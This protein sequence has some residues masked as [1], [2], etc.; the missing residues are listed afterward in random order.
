MRIVFL[1]PTAQLG[2][3]EAALC[4]LLRGLGAVRPDWSLHVIAAEDGPLLNQMTALGITHE[5]LALPPALRSL[6]EHEQGTSGLWRLGRGSILAIGYMRKLRRRIAALEPSAV[7]S[8]GVKMHLLAALVHKFSRRPIPLVWHLHD[9][10]SNRRFTSRALRILGGEC[11]AAIANSKSVAADAATVLRVQRGIE[12]I[13][14]AVDTEVYRPEGARLDLDASSGLPARPVGVVRV[15]LLATFAKWK[16]HEIFLRA[17]AAISPVKPIRFYIVGGPIYATLGSQWKME[18]LRRKADALGLGERIG[19]TGFAEDPASAVRALDV[20]VHASTSPEPFGLVIIQAM[21][22]Q[23]ALITSA[24]G[25]AGELVEP[26]VDCLTYEAA[27]PVA[28]AA[29]VETLT[30]DADLRARLGAAGRAK[31]LAKFSS[32]AL[33]KNAAL[34]YDSLVA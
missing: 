32:E 1:T 13:Y 11:T 22:C 20:V 21:A 12:V 26:G 19:F 18:E 4:E 10:V 23:R 24:L 30:A 7:H 27:D 5:V 34:F 9:Y 33:A 14:N 31:T 3:A 8:N 6:G 15:G 29:S 16:G 25:G 28:L 2:G 17:A